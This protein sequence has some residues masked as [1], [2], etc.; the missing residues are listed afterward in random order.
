M[1]DESPALED[2][3]LRSRGADVDDHE[4]APQRPVTPFLASPARRA[5]RRSVR[6]PA[7][8]LGRP[9]LAPWVLARLGSGPLGSGPPGFWPAGFW[10]GWVWAVGSGPPRCGADDGRPRGWR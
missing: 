9:G 3:Y 1:L 4:V 7:R 5:L 6:R 8:R 2:G 10:A